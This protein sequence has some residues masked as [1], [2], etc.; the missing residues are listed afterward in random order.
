MK[1]YTLEG[2]VEVS[3][4][5]YGCMNLAQAGS[6]DERERIIGT[7]LDAGINFFDHADIYGAGHCE[8]VFGEVLK[9]NPGWRERM[10]LQSKCGIRFPG[11]TYDD[12]APARYDF[13]VEHI[14]RAAD[15][16][17][18]RL[19]IE[20]L[21][22][23]LLHRPDL[24]MQPDEVARAFEQLSESGKV[25]AFGVSNFDAAQ[26]GLLQ[27]ALPAKLSVNQLQLS[28][29]HA[30]LIAHGAKVNTRQDYAG[31]VGTLDYCRL[32]DIRLQ[33][34]SPVAQGRLFA[35]G[36]DAPAHVHQ[37]AALVHELAERHSTNPAAILLGWLLRHPAGIQPVVGTTN[38]DRL[39]QSVA[40]DDVELA[41][42]C[43]V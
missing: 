2:G 3:R 31:A 41:E 36:H 35:P 34:W 37:A 16:I 10:V 4:L 12:A 38:V 7:A 13:S 8:T 26:I 6:T 25:A 19:G 20:R 5:A 39:L 22:I 33:A 42:L 23:L 24:L 17:L 43:V 32:N 21:D 30:E 15:G 18:T 1:T 27:R 11:D 29:L 9:R 14:V 28:L 40:A